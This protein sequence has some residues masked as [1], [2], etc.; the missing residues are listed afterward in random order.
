MSIGDDPDVLWSTSTHDESAP[1]DDNDVANSPDDKMPQPAPPPVQYHGRWDEEGEADE[2]NP[3]GSAGDEEPDDDIP[4]SED[5]RSR[6][7]LRNPLCRCSSQ[8][9][10]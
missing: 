8:R 1:P 4:N 7:S 5:A 2:G 10:K 6:E 9:R 3:S